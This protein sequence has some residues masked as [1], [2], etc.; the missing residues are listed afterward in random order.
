MLEK[1]MIDQ[2]RTIEKPW[3]G[4]LIWAETEDY[5]GKIL[6]IKKDNRLSRQYHKIK[7]E[8]IFVKT[9]ILGLEIGEGDDLQQIA[10]NAGQTFHVKPGTIHRF[11]APYGD[12]ELIEVSTPHLKDVVRLEDDYNRSK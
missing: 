10:L 1:K 7:E 8:T 11:C 4:E 6:F 5:V 12:V 9:G 3:G 2:V